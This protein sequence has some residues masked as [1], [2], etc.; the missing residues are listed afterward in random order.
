MKALFFIGLAML[1]GACHGTVGGALSGR[2]GDRQ[3]GQGGRSGAAG[4]APCALPAVV[5][6]TDDRQPYG[7]REHLAWEDAP[8]AQYPEAP[9]YVI[10]RQSADDPS[11]PV[12]TIGATTF[13]AY[14]DV[15]LRLATATAYHYWVVA[16]SGDCVSPRSNPVTI[17]SPQDRT[18]NGGPA[19]TAEILDDGRLRLTMEVPRDFG[20]GSHF[21]ILEGYPFSEVGAGATQG[22]RAVVELPL[23]QGETSV[24]R[25]QACSAS[26]CYNPSYTKAVGLRSVVENVAFDVEKRK[27]AWDASGDRAD[28]YLVYAD[29][30][31][32]GKRTPVGAV[33][34]SGSRGEF[35][36]PSFD[37]AIGCCFYVRPESGDAS[38]PVLH[39]AAGVC[40]DGVASRS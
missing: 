11:S 23:T 24:F 30:G 5:L 16:H 9:D 38:S 29:C 19:L 22:R 31:D 40:V 27:L 39:P 28:Q 25:A 7:Y 37:S 14:S 3:A 21:R 36:H 10:E 17:D 33:T 2:G 4:D 12:E 13:H 15:S 6:S 35:R 1:L 26:A 34:Q 20:A 18:S 8:G 32:E